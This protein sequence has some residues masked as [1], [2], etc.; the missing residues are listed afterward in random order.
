MPFVT[1]DNVRTFYRLE[2]NDHR[3]VLVFSHSLGCDH[4]MWDVQT[5]D[6]LPYFRILRYDTRGHGASDVPPG[7]ST[8]E[9]L[10][11]DVLALVDSLGIDKFEFCGLSLG[12]MIGQWLAATAPDQ[13]THV[14]LANTSPRMDSAAMEARRTTVLENGTVAIADAVMGRFFSPET[15]AR[16]DPDAAT[17]RRT[18]LSTDRRGYSGCCAAIRDM[19]QTALLKQIRVPTL[20]IVGDCD[21]ST[22]WAGHGEILAREIPHARV[23]HLP[24]A[25]LSN[26]ERPRSFSSALCDFL[27]PAPADILE[28]GNR[29]RRLILGDS[30]VDSAAAKTTAFTRDFQ[31]LITRYAWGTIWTRPG[32]DPRTR[33][34]LALSTFA[35]LGRWEEFRMYIRTSLPHALE[36][37]DLKEAL[38]QAGLYAGVPVANTGFKIAQ[39]EIDS[40]CARKS[41]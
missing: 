23:I 22:P 8:I 3:P 41:E 31:E 20:I 28:A 27:I 36:E 24:T 26:L 1:V 9:R 32:L 40:A 12:G 21:V 34:L 11:R 17:V 10:G 7:D 4:A 5:R 14:I 29:M 33:R 37:C 19:D 18:L 2:G 35:A 13:I 25:H 38:L 6:L 16:H 39:E 15:L 30:H